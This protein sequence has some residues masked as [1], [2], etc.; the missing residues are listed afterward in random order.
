MARESD[1]DDNLSVDLDEIAI[2]LNKVDTLKKNKS[3]ILVA[4]HVE[5]EFGDT[6]DRQQWVTL[7]GDEENRN[8]AKVSCLLNVV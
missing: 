2:D 1:E 5:I 7:E 8:Y 3:W 6:E 4:Y